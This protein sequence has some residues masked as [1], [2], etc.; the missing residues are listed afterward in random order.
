MGNMRVAQAAYYAEHDTYTQSNS[1]LGFEY[2]TSTSKY[3][4]TTTAASNSAFTSQATG[5][6]RGS[7]DTWTVDE[8]GAFNNTPNAC[9]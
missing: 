9:D 3:T 2:N 4:I 8:D 1:N 6:I 5:T 7:T